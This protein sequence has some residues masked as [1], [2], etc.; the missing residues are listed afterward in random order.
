MIEEMRK[1]IAIHQK[2]R[3]KPL[4]EQKIAMEITRVLALSE[5]FF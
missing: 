3:M 2:T 4:E 5:F 1:N